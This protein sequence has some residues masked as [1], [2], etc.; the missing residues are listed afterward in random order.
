MDELQELYTVAYLGDQAEK[1]WKSDVG[2][3]VLQRMEQEEA[4]S[5]ESLVKGLDDVTNRN[6]IAMVR[7]IK[8]WFS[9][10]INE[11]Y[12]VR[13]QLEEME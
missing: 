11:G 1:F 13:E 8:G 5:L 2:A 3:Y 7:S 12:Q 9:E 4:E 6:K 10:L